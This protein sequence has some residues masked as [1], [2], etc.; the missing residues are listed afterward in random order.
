MAASLFVG[1]CAELRFA[2]EHVD[3]KGAGVN[4]FL[5]GKADA[6]NSFQKS[7]THDTFLV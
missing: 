5:E 3:S 7:F 6:V 2:K 4:V 1:N